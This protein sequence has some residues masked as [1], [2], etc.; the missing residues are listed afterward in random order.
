MDSWM[1][2]QLVGAR[3]RGNNHVLVVVNVI[4]DIR[5]KIIINITFRS[6]E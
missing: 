3:V 4:S 1:V 2:A 5:I 6:E